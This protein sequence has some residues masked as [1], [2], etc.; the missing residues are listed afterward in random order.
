M[1]KYDEPV[2][3]AAHRGD[4]AHYPENTLIAFEASL[5]YPID[6]IE[7]DLH[8]TRD[9][10]L[11]L[12]HDHRL[13]RTTDGSGLIR[14]HTLAEIKALDAGSR[15]GEQFA[16]TR[17][18]TF[19]EFL[20]LLQAHP[21]VSINVELKDYPEGDE[22]WAREAADK[23]IAMLGQYGMVERA[24]LNSWSAEMLEYL[25][26]AYHGM[27]PLH[28]YYPYSCMHGV[29]TRDPFD[30]VYC[31]CLYG[32][33][34]QPVLSESAFEAALSRGVEPWVFFSDDSLAH[35]REAI[36]KGAKMITANDP[37]KVLTFLREQGLHR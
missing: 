30:Y 9:G 16:G 31:A 25:D 15:K 34:Q 7:M 33:E 23:A 35:C 21:D 13:E 10:E 1:W 14:D 28:G 24:F 26:E 12:M 19:A 11:I 17:V 29:R 27:F 3:V 8:M 2:R 36:D 37:N 20:A 5:K 4:R 18:P 22:K 6:Q 32:G